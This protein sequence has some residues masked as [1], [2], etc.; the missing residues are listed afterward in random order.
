MWVAETRVLRTGC[1]ERLGGVES[2]LRLLPLL[3]IEGANSPQ[4]ARRKQGEPHVDVD[5]QDETNW[6]GKG[7][8]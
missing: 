4:C 5:G 8:V 1:W 3:F 6:R 7:G 2:Y